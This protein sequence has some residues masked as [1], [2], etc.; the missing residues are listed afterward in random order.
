[1]PLFR[2]YLAV[3]A[4]G[5]VAR[6]DNSVDWLHDYDPA[7][8]GYAEFMAG[9]GSIVMGRSSY[10]AARSLSGDWL[11]G[12]KRA[13]VVTGRPLADPPP[14]TETRPAD[15]AALAAELRGQS[16]GDV[17]L[18]GGP[19][20]WAGFLDAGALDR[21]ELYVVPVLI[22]EG[23]PLLPPQRRDRMLRL[24]ESEPLSRGVAK[25]VYAVG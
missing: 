6:A 23:I 5:F 8:F 4:D 24:L 11:Y 16:D 20:L 13:Y 25:L 12:E 1:M 14:R 9:I 18:Y 7:E 2:A 15:F 10:E 3:S 21:F 19:K 22:G 17:W